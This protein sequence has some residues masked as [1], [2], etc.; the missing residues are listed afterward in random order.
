MQGF[1][2]HR[3]ANRRQPICGVG[4]ASAP[5]MSDLAHQGCSVGV[6]PLRKALQMRN[7][8]VSADVQLV[9]NVGALRASEVI[10]PPSNA[11]TILRLSKPSNS[12]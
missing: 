12:N 9:K 5:K 3:R 11:A 10:A 7:Y 2:H 4:L 6:H 8:G 1:A